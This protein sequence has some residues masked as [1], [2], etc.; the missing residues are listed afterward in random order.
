MMA[1]EGRGSSEAA[2]SAF[3]KA[4]NKAGILRH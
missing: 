1:I 3:I 4:A 2:Q